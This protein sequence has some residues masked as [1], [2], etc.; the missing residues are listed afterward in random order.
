MPFCALIN[1]VLTFLFSSWLL[2]IYKNIFPIDLISRYHRI[3]IGSGPDPLPPSTGI[4]WAAWPPSPAG[5]SATQHGGRKQSPGTRLPRHLLLF[6]L[7]FLVC[8]TENNQ[9]IYLKRMIRWV[10]ACETLRTL[11]GKQEALHKH[12][13]QSSN[14]FLLLPS[15]VNQLCALVSHA[16]PFCSL[17]ALAYSRLPLP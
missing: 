2:L 5:P 15:P 13:Q 6:C 10:S 17:M 9:T 8:K 12:Y 14:S 16:R 3:S 4:A 7:S 1:A 11:P